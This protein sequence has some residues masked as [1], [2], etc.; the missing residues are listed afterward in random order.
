MQKRK[1]TVRIAGKDYG[2][3][4]PVQEEEKFRRAARGINDLIAGYRSSYAAEPEDYLAMA[5]LQMAVDKVSLEMDRTLGDDQR[6]SLEEL[7]AK[8]D[9]Y[10]EEI[11]E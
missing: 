1:I 9:R 7:G 5:A 3:H 10:L 2:M 6:R 8:I 4:I 11:T